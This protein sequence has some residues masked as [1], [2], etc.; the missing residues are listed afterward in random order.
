M[1]C[2]E[3]PRLDSRPFPAPLQDASR[4]LL[5]SSVRLPPDPTLRDLAQM[6]RDR[7][8]AHRQQIDEAAAEL[9]VDPLL[10][11]LGQLNYD[12]QM[13]Q[14]ACSTMALATP[15][16][17][18]AARNMDWWP[19]D[20]IARASCVV[21]AGQGHSAG[22]VGGVG[23]VTGLS[24]RGFGVV[25][26]AVVGG[27][28]DLDGYPVLLF[29]RHLLDEALDFDDALRRATTTRLASSALITLVGTRNHERAVVERTPRHAEVRRPQGDRPL[30][31]T[32]HYRQMAPP[33]EGCDRYPC[34]TRWADDLPA[35]PAAEDLLGLLRRGPVFN[36]ITAQHIVMHPAAGVLRMWVPA[37]LLGE[38]RERAGSEVLRELLEGA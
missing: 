8:P 31:T 13:G 6:V 36:E 24:R 26:N 19:A 28:P 11:T 12:L 38:Q 7:Y 1:T 29:L 5:A 30:L 27:P 15:D 18:V 9:G 22:F 16:G 23:V 25:L 2:I 4:A 3:T 10:L 37:E 17:P 21:P 34:L 14:F 35:R 32:N 20:L 33:D